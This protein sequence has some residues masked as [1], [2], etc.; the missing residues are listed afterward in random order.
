MHSRMMTFKHENMTLV[1]FTVGKRNY[2][3]RYG[4]LLHDLPVVAVLF[5]QINNNEG[6]IA[7][8]G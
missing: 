1:H 3:T 6:T 2:F 5:T 4:I 7:K 8:L